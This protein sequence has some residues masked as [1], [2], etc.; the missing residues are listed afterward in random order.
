MCNLYL[1]YYATVPLSMSCFATGGGPVNYE[2]G[3]APFSFAPGAARLP[4]TAFGGGFAAEIPEMGQVGGLGFAPDGRSLYV[5]HRGSRPWGAGS[6]VPMSEYLVANK[7]AI[8]EAAMVEIDVG[9]GGELRSWGAGVFNCPHGVSTDQWGNVWV[10]DVGLHQAGEKPWGLP[11]GAL[12]ACV[13]RSAVL[14]R[15]KRRRRD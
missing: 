12:C 10:A 13:V 4:L 14:E 11:R 15:E 5:F 6:I 9:S 1:Q 7:T 3:P 8:G 2:L